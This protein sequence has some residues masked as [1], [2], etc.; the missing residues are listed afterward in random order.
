MHDF[1]AYVRACVR[2]D[3]IS[4]MHAVDDRV[5]PSLLAS[6]KAMERLVEKLLERQ[7]KQE[8]SELG[9][10]KNNAHRKLKLLGPTSRMN[11][12]RKSSNNNADMCC[13]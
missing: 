3:H 2:S 11:K 5:L 13:V 12:G 4:H 7:M 6:F 1:G 8:K 10:R 9:S